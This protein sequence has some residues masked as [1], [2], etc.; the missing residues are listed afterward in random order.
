MYSIDVSKQPSFFSHQ[1]K[2]RNARLACRPL[3]CCSHSR[4]KDSDFEQF[5]LDSQERIIKATE[6][7]DGSR[8]FLRDPWQREGDAP[9]PGHG[10]T[11]VLE[12]GDLLEKAAVNVSIVQGTLSAERA[13]AMSSRGRGIDPEGGQSYS[14]AALSLVY[15]PAHPLVPTL[16]ADVR[17]FQVGDEAWYGGGCD[18][19]PAYLFED[20]GVEF[21]TFWSDLCGR[22]QE[23][24]YAQ[25]K[26]WC[27]QYFYLPNWKEHRG[28]GGIFF[29]DLEA[30][31]SSFD[32][33]QFVRDVAGGIL[34]SW[35][36]IAVRRRTQSFTQQQRQ[37][38][39]HRR[40]AYVCFNT[41]YDRGFRFGL[42]GGRIESLM[43]SFPPLVAW[44]YKVVPEENS[45]ENALLQVL[46]QPRDWVTDTKNDH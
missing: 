16:R 2:A 24:L 22:H 11:A 32:V 4:R 26:K 13:K 21:H 35:Q 45:R 39:L 28:I 37:W 27:D 8:T 38:Q 41:L 17:R 23:D 3:K 5:L 18:L 14:A 7:L 19:T 36:P 31:P 34:P 15:H 10:I 12:G 1:S 9:N 30:E 44:N 33:E 25:Y 46:K 29:D 43:V 20:D 42:N 40:G 6:L